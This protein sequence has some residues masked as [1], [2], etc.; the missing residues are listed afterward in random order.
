MFG[1]FFRMWMVDMD[2]IDRATGAKTAL[3]SVNGQLT[4]GTSGTILNADI[5][6]LESV[7]VIDVQNYKT[8]YIQFAMTVAAL[9]AFQVEFR[10]HASGAYF[11]VASAAGDFTSPVNPVVK[12]SGDLTIAGVGSHWLKLDVE[13]VES[14]KIQAAGTSSVLTGYYGTN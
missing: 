5:D 1:R 10:V 4:T 9:T 7:A 6:S 2:T 3:T 13:G 11:V 14:V 12:A 8:L